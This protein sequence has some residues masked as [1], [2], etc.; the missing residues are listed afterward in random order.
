MKSIAVMN[1]KGGVGKT[2][3]AI[4][5]AEELAVAGKRSILVD[6][7]GQMSLTR[8]YLPSLDPDTTPTL[9][10]LLTGSAEPL[11]SDNVQFVNGPRISLLPASSGLYYLDAAAIRQGSARQ[12]ALRDFRDAV[13]E[14][15]A[16]EYIIFDCPPGFTCASIS[17]LLA[18]DEV[19]IPMLVDGFSMWGVGDLAA[20]INSIKSA[21]HRIK[22]AGV[23]ITQ[24][25]NS[26]AVLQGERLLRS[27]KL[28]VFSTV[29]R[30]TDKVPES[31][32]VRQPL[33]EYSLRSAA[34]QDYRAWMK[35]YLGEEVHMSGKI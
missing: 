1:L 5:L 9:E 19:V 34:G 35:E 15:A 33:R 10:C 8:F 24:W 25:H 7:D 16:A 12:L 29:I 3:T 32:F 18:A 17:A 14:D 30:R 28:P 4:N 23:L 20:Q 22:V 31:T 2:I 13:A 6:C 11:W 27:L 21:N 26:P